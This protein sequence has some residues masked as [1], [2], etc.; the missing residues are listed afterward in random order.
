[1]NNLFW[2]YYVLTISLMASA[3][4]FVWI[5][6]VR[7]YYYWIQEYCEKLASCNYLWILTYYQLLLIIVWHIAWCTTWSPQSPLLLSL[8]LFFPKQRTLRRTGDVLRP[9]KKYKGRFP[10]F[11]IAAH[12]SD[13]GGVV[14][15]S[16]NSCLLKTIPVAHTILRVRTRLWRNTPSVEHPT[17][18][19]LRLTKF[20]WRA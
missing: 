18:S 3:R 2:F 6:N 14:I 9:I 15:M 10:K 20:I 7:D 4:F 13:L 12:E 19:N 1:M 16:R 11:P 5:K 8:R 17:L